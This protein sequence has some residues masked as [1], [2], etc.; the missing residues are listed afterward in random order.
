MSFVIRLHLTNRE[1]NCDKVNEQAFYMYGV[2]LV[3]GDRIKMLFVMVF[4]FSEEKSLLGML[5]VLL[6]FV[7]NVVLVL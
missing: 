6:E 5:K 3:F 1:E 7:N 4:V 2:G